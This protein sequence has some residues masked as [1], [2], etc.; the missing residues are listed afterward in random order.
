RTFYADMPTGGA[1]GLKAAR[2][3]A[4]LSYRGYPTY[5]ATQLESTNEKQDDFKASSYQHYQGEKLVKRFNAYS[6]WFLTKAMDS[7][8]VGRGRPGIP[9]ALQRIKAETL[10]IGISTDLLFPVTEQQFLASHIPR[11]T[12]AEISSFYGHDGFLIE[13][14]RISESI[15]RFLKRDGEPEKT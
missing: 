9:E 10:V 4:L 13:T 8:N 14:K 3:I 6:Y 12:Y 11:A 15:S 2:S 1:R 5:G 7:H